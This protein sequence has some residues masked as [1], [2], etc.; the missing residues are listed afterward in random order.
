M[1]SMEYKKGAD[2]ITIQ[3]YR[4]A[5]PEDAFGMYS[6]ERSSDLEFLPVGEK[7]REIRRIC[8]SLPGICI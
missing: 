7:R 3:A 8:I 4:H 2:Y 5:T 6:S 1:T